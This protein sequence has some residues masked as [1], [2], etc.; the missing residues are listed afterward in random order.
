MQAAIVTYSGTATAQ[1]TGT[2]AGLNTGDTFAW[3]VSWDST[4]LDEVPGPGSILFDF[5]GGRMFASTGLVTGDPGFEGVAFFVADFTTPQAT[6]GLAL[7]GTIVVGVFPGFFQTGGPLP[8]ILP[9]GQ[10]INLY[11]HSFPSSPGSRMD[12]STTSYTLQSAV[13]EPSTWVLVLA[14]C[15]TLAIPRKR[16]ALSN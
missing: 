5:G 16:Q 12:A 10:T 4:S 6:G 1:V 2:I 14:G 3:I 15:A 11:A 8:S 7:P 13:P 9:P